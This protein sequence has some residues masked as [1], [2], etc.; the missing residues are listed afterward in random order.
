MRIIRDNWHARGARIFSGAD[1]LHDVAF[2][3]DKRVTVQE[4]IDLDNLDRLVARDGLGD[5]NVNLS[6][7]EIIQDQL[8]AGE[9]FVE[10][11]D[12]YDITVR[13]LQGDGLWRRDWIITDRREAWSELAEPAPPPR[14]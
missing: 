5:E 11:Q 12:V 9:R 2:G 3:R 4:E 8:L 1:H 13:V 14:T 6:L 10:A 7:D